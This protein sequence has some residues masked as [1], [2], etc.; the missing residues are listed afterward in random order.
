M[1][2]IG[3]Y[4]SS[5]TSFTPNKIIPSTDSQDMITFDWMETVSQ[6]SQ[7][8]LKIA[9]LQVF[10]PNSTTV[11][12]DYSSLECD[13]HPPFIKV[14]K[15]DLTTGWIDFNQLLFYPSVNNLYVDILNV[16]LG[17]CDVYNGSGGNSNFLLIAY[18]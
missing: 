10:I 7:R 4:A 13:L 3:T 11:N 1:A 2:N 18:L 17:T 5:Y 9:T 12:F 16:G 14:Y 8:F 6:F 15:Q